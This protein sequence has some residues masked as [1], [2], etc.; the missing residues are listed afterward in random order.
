[1]KKSLAFCS[2]A[3]LSGLAS[4][5]GYGVNCQD[6]S[7][8]FPKQVLSNSD[9]LDVLADRSEITKSD[10]YLLTGNV[11][12]NSR[13]YYLAADEVVIKK[14]DKTSTAKGQVSYQDHELMF[15]GD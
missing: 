7:L 3:L 13:D 4:A 5:Q 12:L 15:V 8:L 10:T 9:A 11:S 2:F 6:S 1:M 14:S